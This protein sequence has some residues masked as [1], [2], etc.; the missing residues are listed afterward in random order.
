MATFEIKN[1]WTNAATQRRGSA[2]ARHPVARAKLVHTSHNG[3]QIVAYLTKPLVD[4][5][6]WING[7][8]V[9]VSWLD[10]ETDLMVRL[11]PAH[12]GIRALP[13]SKKTTTCRLVVSGDFIAKS[14]CAPVRDVPFTICDSGAVILYLPRDWLARDMIRATAPKEAA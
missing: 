7:G 2:R 10:A 8:V 12:K 1:R 5:A 9:S 11:T 6:G 4:Q 3:R 13:D 14:A